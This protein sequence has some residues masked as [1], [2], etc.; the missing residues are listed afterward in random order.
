MKTSNVLL[1]NDELICTLQQEFNAGK[2]FRH[3][4]IDGFLDEDLAER[5][6]KHFPKKEE[7]SR[8]YRGLNENKSEGADF[9]Q[10]DP[11]FTELR[12]MLNS[13]EF[14]LILKQ[15]TGI[16]GMFSTED[17][18]GSGVHQGENGSF[19][20]VHIDFNIHHKRKVHRRINLLIFLNK[21]WQ[22]TYGGALELWNED[23]SKMEQAYL[24]L[25]NRC[26]I[27]ETNDTSY[28]GYSRISVPEGI[29]RKSFYTYYYTPLNE[30]AGKYH[31]TVFK[32]RP[33]E[34][35]AKKVKTNIKERLKN[36]VKRTLLA[37]NIR[38]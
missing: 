16:D 2:P 5:L 26:V 29:S 15:I 8:H 21:D 31:D 22:E 13:D 6:C 25:F 20:D 4:K 36:T 23:V 35:L 24:P 7:L 14:R 34:G 28:H 9:L 11:A 10:F 32:A 18:F 3:V 1:G 17:A 12:K 30:Y 27:F 38:F 33:Q 19:L 37:L